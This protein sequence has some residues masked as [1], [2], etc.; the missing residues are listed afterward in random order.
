MEASKR[1][2]EV[3]DEAVLLFQ[4]NDER[5]LEKFKEALSI[6]QNEDFIEGIIDSLK[7]L[8]LYY[9]MH[10]EQ[11]ETIKY[12]LLCVD[13]AKKIN[14][15]SALIFC[16]V[17]LGHIYYR[18]ENPSKSLEYLHQGEEL[19]D[20]NNFDK[21]EV[22]IYINLALVYNYLNDYEKDFQYNHKALLIA[23]KNNNKEQILNIFLNI[24]GYYFEIQDWDNFEEYAK[25]ALVLAEE[26]NNDISK[27]MNLT[28]LAVV[29]I[30]KNK[31]Q[32]GLTT[33]NKIIKMDGFKNIFPYQKS[34]IFMNT[35]KCYYAL[36][37]YNSAEKNIQKALK[38]INKESLTKEH[39]V[40]NLIRH[41]NYF[42]QKLFKKDEDLLL[43]TLKIIEDSDIKGYLEKVY[44][45]LARLYDAT[46]QW[47]KASVF[48]QKTTKLLYKKFND[49]LSAKLA[50]MQTKFD[51]ERAHHEND[52]L[53]DKNKRLQE[54]NAELRVAHEKIL[55]LE[56]KNTIGAM[57][58]TASHELNQPLMV[59]K[60]NAEMIRLFSKKLNEKE[61][62]WL[63]NIENGVENIN[64][65]LTKFSENKNSKIEKYVHDTDMITFE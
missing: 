28:N 26:L 62:K 60:A 32:E 15:I 40:C 8:S 35:A 39:I 30:K 22:S 27:I 25:K 12:S 13:Y 6:A 7:R 10:N 20:E 19:I 18:L 33:L 4:K 58:V 2:T 16:Y 63:V 53:A 49:D 24:Q 47:E 11:E 5:A 44:T 34:T 36:K 9:I 59:I 61:Q 42:A 55:E 64:S 38:I 21:N 56:R 37:E 14:D 43:K 23:E 52:I 17:N 50:E 65:I 48:W 41:E 51:I 29:S 31:Y 46:K 54:M 3:Y 45:Y 1:Y 57:A